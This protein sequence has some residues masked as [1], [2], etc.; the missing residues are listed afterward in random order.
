MHFGIEKDAIFL[1]KGKDERT[2]RCTHRKTSKVKGVEEI[3]VKQIELLPGFWDCHAFLGIMV[4]HLFQGSGRR[5]LLPQPWPTASPFLSRCPRLNQ[6][7]LTQDFQC[8]NYSRPRQSGTAALPT[9][10]S[11]PREASSE[12]LTLTLE[13][14]EGCS[15]WRGDRNHPLFLLLP[16]R[17]PK[18]Q[19]RMLSKCIFREWKHVADE[20]GGAFQTKSTSSPICSLLLGPSIQNWPSSTLKWSK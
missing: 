1:P 7:R 8:W 5:G 15:S 14:V 3:L 18:R 2:Q 6:S 4:S 17:L 11:A 19:H 12:T 16:Y 9:L 20:G 13:L 10:P